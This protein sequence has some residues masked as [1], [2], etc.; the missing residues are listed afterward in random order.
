[1][2]TGRRNDGGIKMS[3]FTKDDILEKTKELSKMIAA[4]EEVEFFKRAEEQVN[5]NEKIRSLIKMVKDL[6]K[7]AVNLEHLEKPEAL[8]K[9]ESM[10]EKVQRDLDEMPIIQDFKQSQLEVNDLLQMVTTVISNTVTDE[11]IKATQG[12]ILSGET[13][14]KIKY[15]DCSHEH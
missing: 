1:M 13:G 6:Q 5:E 8:A 3:V 11:I 12:N 15:S 14:S 10:L 2:V 7:Q 4:T 9:T